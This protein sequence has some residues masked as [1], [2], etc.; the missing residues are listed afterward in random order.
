MTGRREEQDYSRLYCSLKIGNFDPMKSM[1]IGMGR[2]RVQKSK[3]KGDLDTFI[4]RHQVFLKSPT[5]Q[6]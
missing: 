6:I 3:M 4:F 5:L 2:N 1:K